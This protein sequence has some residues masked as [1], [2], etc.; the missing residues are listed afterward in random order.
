MRI[1]GGLVINPGEAPVVRDF[2]IDDETGLI[3]STDKGGETI[4]ASGKILTPGFIDTHIHG[5]FGTDTS[6][7]SVDAIEN[8]SDNLP[9]FGVAAFCPTTMTT[10]VDVIKNALNAV[11]EAEDKGAK[12]IGVHLE[13]PFM[14]PAMG[15]VQTPELCIAPSKAGVIVD[16]LESLYPGLMKII[17][18]APECDG[19]VDFINKYSA[20][21]VMSLAHTEAD[22]S[23]AIA[24]FDA[25]AKSVTHLLNAMTTFGKRFPGVPAA[26]YDKKSYVEIICDGYHIEPPVLRMLF[27]LYDEDKILIVSDAMR[28]AGMPDGEY[29]LADTKVEVRGGRTY[30]G[31]KEN[32]AGSVTN[33]AEEV[34]RLVSFGVPADKVIKAATINH[35]YR[36]GI[37]PEDIGYGKI[38]DG[39]IGFIN[40]FD[41]KMHLIDVI[42]HK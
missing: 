36:L 25:G 37:S 27:D 13:G 14:S 3:S 29:Y 12:I 40:V 39:Y 16:E 1:V 21:Y 22:Y 2:Y 4:D 42:R 5:C 6:D 28:G 30:F 32:L 18:V 8:M 38:N 34:E 23:T 35:L 24:A 20:K 15:G 17:D 9:K 19:G 10:T 31:P 7:G 11:S 33:I 41:S 26:A